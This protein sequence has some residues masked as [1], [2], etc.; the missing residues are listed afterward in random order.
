M[1][2]RQGGS[3]SWSFVYDIQQLE[4]KQS[5]QAEQSGMQ[6][7]LLGFSYKQTQGHNNEQAGC[8]VKAVLQ[9]QKE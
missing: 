7:A 9:K 3:Q 6:L 2:R 1:D 5:Q 4:M 8:F